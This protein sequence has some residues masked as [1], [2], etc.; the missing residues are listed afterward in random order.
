MAG[1]PNDGFLLNALK[2]LFRQSTFRSLEIHS[3]R[4]YKIYI[5]SVI[6][7]QLES[8]RNYQGFSIIFPKILDASFTKVRI[9]FLESENFSFPFYLKNSFIRGVKCKKKI[10][11]ENRKEFIR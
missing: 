8:F 7:W 2:T 10:T 3:Y 4:R 1:A 9:F 11:S 5:C 6:L